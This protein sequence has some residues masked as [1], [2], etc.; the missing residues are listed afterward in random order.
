MKV[1]FGNGKTIM[2]KTLLIAVALFSA[3]TAA[4]A[5]KVKCF[6]AA[7]GAK[8]A[9]YAWM[10]GG[11]RPKGVPFKVMDPSGAV[12]LEGKTDGKGEFSFVPP[13]HCDLTIIVYAG[14]GHEGKF[15]IRA[16]ELPDADAE[17]ASAD[18]ADSAEKGARAEPASSKPAAAPSAAERSPVSA[19]SV[20]G[21][22]IGELVE[23]AV[24]K[25]IAPLRAELAEFEDRETFRDVFAG[26]G[27]IAG[28]AG[29]A[30]FFLGT[31]RKNARKE[32]SGR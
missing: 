7:D 3:A 12:L 22:N 20:S 18:S 25:Q 2:G 1:F 10:S 11:A 26:L 27:Y 16:D 31:K 29:A 9:G 14:P 24:S 8:V 28:I 23:R 21:N 15:T 30:F 19:I 6:A 17:S 32:E 5:H 13:K 4:M